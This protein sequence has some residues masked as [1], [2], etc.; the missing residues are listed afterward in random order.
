MSS[1]SIEL[2]PS[3]LATAE[4]YVW[5]D[6]CDGWHLLNLPDLSVI[7]ELVPPGGAETRHYHCRA[8]QFFYILEGQATLEFSDRAIVFS[9]GQ[10]VHVAPGVQHRFRNNS[11]SPVRFLVISSPTTRGD[12]ANT[13]DP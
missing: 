11:A 3:S 13:A 8:R 10:G 12:R 7:E 4:H 6:G 9:S 1:P 2:E 5:G